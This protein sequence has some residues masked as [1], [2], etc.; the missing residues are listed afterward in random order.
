MHQRKGEREKEQ[1]EN[2][3]ERGRTSDKGGEKKGRQKRLSFSHLE[4][5]LAAS[6]SATPGFPNRGPTRRDRLPNSVS[7]PRIESANQ[8]ERDGI[9]VRR[10]NKKKRAKKWEMHVDVTVNEGRVC[11]KKET[12]ARCTGWVRKSDWLTCDCDSRLQFLFFF[13]P[14]KL[15]RVTLRWH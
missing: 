4:N 15:T 14:W 3:R 11:N 10:V 8:M 7:V 1:K 12:R 6:R 9:R 13:L 2:E 5:G